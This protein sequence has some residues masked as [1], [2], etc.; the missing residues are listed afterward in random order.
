MSLFSFL[1]WFKRASFPVTVRTLYGPVGSR[2]V[3]EG[4]SALISGEPRVAEQLQPVRVGLARQQ[5]GGTFP[6]PLGMLPAQEPPM[7]QEELHQ[8]QGITA[9]VPP[10][11]EITPQPAVEVLDDPA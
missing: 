9:H 7:V 10:E 11:E 2:Q 6:L 5:F 3:S 4:C 1:A 8:R